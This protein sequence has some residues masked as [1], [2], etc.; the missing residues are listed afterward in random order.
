M[1][2]INKEHLKARS[3][4]FT[5]GFTQKDVQGI[6]KLLDDNFALFDPA[7][8]WIKGKKNVLDVLQDLFDKTKKVSYDVTNIYQ[9][10]TTSILEFILT[11]DDTTLYGV[12]FIEWKDNRMIE[13]RCYYNPQ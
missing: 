13:L 10:K 6:S 2:T 3:L 8:K 11:L 1:L 7:L 9:D 4:E 5:Q 12:D